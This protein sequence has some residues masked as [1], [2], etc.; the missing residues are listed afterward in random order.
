MSSSLPNIET[1]PQLFAQILVRRFLANIVDLVIMSIIIFF[2]FIILFFAGIV[3]F[4]IFWLTI[5]I[6]IPLSILLY[7]IFTLGSNM[8]ATIGMK[9]F[10]II[11]VPTKGLALSG[12]GVLFHPFIFWL[13]IWIFAPLLIIGLFTKRRQLLHDLLT[14]TMMVRRSAL[15]R[16]IY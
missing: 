13:T 4:G 15:E 5:P 12:W 3:S 1:A 8:R 14:S 9:I 2:L 6:I 10:D 7:Y 16:Q 11:L